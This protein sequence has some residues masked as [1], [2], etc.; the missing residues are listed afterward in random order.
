MCQKSIIVTLD[1]ASLEGLKKAKYSLC[2]AKKVNDAYNVIWRSSKKYLARNTFSWKP[3]YAVFGTNTYEASVKVTA[4]T[5]VVNA[6]LGQQCTLDE[7]GIMKDAI[8]GTHPMSVTIN[9]E[10]GPIHSG[11]SQ[12][13]T[14]DG[15]EET[16]PIYVSKDSRT[17]GEIILTPK[18]K[19]LI[20]FEANVETSTIFEDAKTNAIEIDLTNKEAQTVSFDFESG[21]WKVLETK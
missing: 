21:N 18:E 11:I 4:D 6:E 9:N 3:K 14:I 7:N 17:K 5:A 1:A 10:Y 13:C 12:I 2:F 15:I 20:W 16:T 8:S 19:V